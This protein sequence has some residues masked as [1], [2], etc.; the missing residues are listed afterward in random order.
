M[1]KWKKINIY[2]HVYRKHIIYIYWKSTFPDKMLS[3]W[4]RVQL[5]AELDLCHNIDGWRLDK[6]LK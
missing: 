4:G 1:N 6:W 3:Q 2:I 5:E